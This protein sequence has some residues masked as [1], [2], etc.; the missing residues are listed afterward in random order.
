MNNTYAQDTSVSVEKSRAEIESILSR[1]GATRFGYMVGDREAIIGFMAN[2][3]FVKFVLP[4][5]D[6]QSS[7]FQI[8]KW[9]YRGVH[10]KYRDSKQTPEKAR[11][12]WE[13][14]CR[15]RWR[16]LALCVKAKLEAVSAGITTFEAEFLAHI[17]IPGGGTLGDR[18][19][20]QLNEMQRT[21]RLP[22]MMMLEAPKQNGATDI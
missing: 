10:Q 21:G 5:P 22:S 2:D 1:Y 14:A 17:V 13:Q 7:D 9:F 8:K 19:I 12:L 4:L 18:F 15:S 6:I 3:K 16:S 20:P 11:Q